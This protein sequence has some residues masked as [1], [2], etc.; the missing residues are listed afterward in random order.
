VFVGL[1]LQDVSG[2]GVLLRHLCDPVPGV[3][4]AEM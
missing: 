3:V 1:R 4:V 2:G